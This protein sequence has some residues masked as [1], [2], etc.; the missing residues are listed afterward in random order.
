MSVQPLD[1]VALRSKDGP[2]ITTR[3][4]QENSKRPNMWMPE[5]FVLTVGDMTNEVPVAGMCC[6]FKLT[7]TTMPAPTTANKASAAKQGMSSTVAIYWC[8]IPH[9]C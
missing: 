3:R 4:R 2:S 1:S 5:G 9:S 8:P 7:S 6:N